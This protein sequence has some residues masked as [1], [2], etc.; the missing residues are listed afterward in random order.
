[1]L[2]PEIKIVTWVHKSH[3]ELALFRFF[4]ELAIEWGDYWLGKPAMGEGCPLLDNTGD[5]LNQL[6]KNKILISK[7]FDIFRNFKFYYLI[8]N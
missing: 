2:S 3:L 6:F 8:L 1:M 4:W 5:Y 7:L